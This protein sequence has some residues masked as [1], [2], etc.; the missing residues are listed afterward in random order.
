M[1]RAEIDRGIWQAVP[2]PVNRHERRRKKPR[3]KSKAR[4]T[5]G[6]TEIPGADHL[7]KTH[8]RQ[9]PTGRHRA[10]KTSEILCREKQPRL[11]VRQIPAVGEIRQHRAKHR[12]AD[13]NQHESKMQKRPFPARIRRSHSLGRRSESVIGRLRHEPRVSHARLIRTS[14]RLLSSPPNQSVGGPTSTTSILSPRSSPPLSA[15]GTGIPPTV[16]SK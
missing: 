10:Q 14:A 5:Q 6:K 9:K 3:P 15:A 12:H 11:A 2:E 7:R 13:A 16:P 8:A 4:Q 1:W